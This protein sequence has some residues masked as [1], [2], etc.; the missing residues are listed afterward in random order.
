MHYPRL[1]TQK[2]K[3]PRQHR[4]CCSGVRVKHPGGM[5]GTGV[6]GCRK[7]L[8]TWKLGSYCV[9]LICPQEL[10]D[11]EWNRQSPKTKDFKG[12]GWDNI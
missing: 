9:E 12:K 7:Q 4:R 3:V 8:Q 1:Q 10:L 2:A 6:G 11:L 5:A